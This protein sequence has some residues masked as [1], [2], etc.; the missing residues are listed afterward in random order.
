[1]LGLGIMLYT[2]W[3]SE[4]G[5][6]PQ[7]IKAITTMKGKIEAARDQKLN[8]EVPSTNAQSEGFPAECRTNSYKAIV[9]A[10]LTKVLSTTFKKDSQDYQLVLTDPSQGKQVSGETFKY[11]YCP[12][13]NPDR[14]GFR[15]LALA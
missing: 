8:G 11:Y 6:D 5:K 12:S 3:N 1:M 14:V 9:D 7:R 2:S 15:V 13:T 4:T 10:C